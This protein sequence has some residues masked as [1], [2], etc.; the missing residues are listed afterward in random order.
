VPNQPASSQLASG[1]GLLR[2]AVSAVRSMTRFAGS[3]FKTASPDSV[4][5]RLRTCASCEHH[6]G[7]RCKICGCF[8]NI[9]ARLLQEECPIGKWPA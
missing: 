9:K 5:K 1:P 6:T 8:T 7:V 4:Q 3:G 2:M